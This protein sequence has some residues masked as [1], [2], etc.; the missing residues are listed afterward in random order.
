MFFNVGCIGVVVQTTDIQQIA[1]G[2]TYNL[3]TTLYK[4][5]IEEISDKDL[6]EFCEWYTGFHGTKPVAAT[7]LT[8]CLQD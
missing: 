2:T 4:M 7:V 3:T 5:N 8:T 6:R 1:I